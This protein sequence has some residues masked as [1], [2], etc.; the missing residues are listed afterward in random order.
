[1]VVMAGAKTWGNDK[2][3]QSWVARTVREERARVGWSAETLAERLGCD[4]STVVRLEKGDTP[5]TLG[6]AE[7]LAEAFRIPVF[8]FIHSL[9]PPDVEPDIA[10][11]ERWAHGEL[12]RGF[13]ETMR[14]ET[15]R[16]VAGLAGD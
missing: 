15:V 7:L 1:M 4:R 10:Q 13:G 14:R 2:K 16:E 3:H 6:L 5:V 12:K 8:A 9:V 11:L